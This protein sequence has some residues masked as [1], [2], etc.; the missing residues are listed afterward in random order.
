MNNCESLNE[1]F[2]IRLTAKKGRNPFSKVNDSVKG[3]K[4]YSQQDDD[5][6]RIHMMPFFHHHPYTYALS[7]SQSL[8][9]PTSLSLTHLDTY[10]CTCVCM[11][12]LNV[13]AHWKAWVRKNCLNSFEKRCFKVFRDRLIAKSANFLNVGIFLWCVFSFLSNNLISNNSSLLSWIKTRLGV[14]MQ[15]D[16]K[17][18]NTF[19]R[20]KLTIRESITL[21]LT[22][23]LTDLDLTK[24]VKL[25]LIQYW[26]SSWIQTKLTGGQTYFPLRLV[27]SAFN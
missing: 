7:L 26:Q 8:P 13:F 6:G 3:E 20:R 22:S 23:C 25:M 19:N 17:T 4:V 18:T 2:L 16:H 27:F 5:A 14:D 21:R 12:I 10:T 9:S 1:Y 15:A 11:F 24:Q